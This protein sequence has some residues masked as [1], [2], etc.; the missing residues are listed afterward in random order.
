MFLINRCSRLQFLFILIGGILLGSCSGRQTLR[1]VFQKQTAHERYEQSLRSA[2][3]DN[4][5]LGRDWIEAS[6]KALR[7]SIAVSKLPFQETGYFRADRAMATGYRFKAPRGQVV[8]ITVETKA[9]QNVNIFLDLFEIQVDPTREPRRV[10]S[11][12]SASSRLEYRIDNDRPHLLRLQPELLRSGQYT[13]TILSRPSLAFPVQGKDSKAIQSVFGVPRDGGARRH[14]GVDIFAARGT[15][16]VASA[17]G[18]VTRVSETPRGGKVVWL[19]DMRNRQN[20]YYAHLDAQLVQVGQ[21]V[22]VGDTLG[23]VGNTGN[24]ITTTP[25]LHFGIYKYGEGAI[26][27]YMHVHQPPLTPPQIKANLDHLGNWGRI[28]SKNVNLRISPDP[29]AAV[30]ASL[31]QHTPLQV[32]GGTDTWFR[33]RTPDGVEGYVSASLLEPLNKPI[34]FEQL[35]AQA[36]LLEEADLS[37]APLD[38]SSLSSKVPVL[39]A[40]K[41]FLLVQNEAGDL[42]WLWQN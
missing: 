5:G 26:D 18:R 9:K 15:P 20:L 17:E 25:H 10:A 42:G 36:I 7:D 11:A 21:H 16:V 3:L 30:L 35:R 31:P 2:N 39:A 38:S 27:P 6:H 41:S 12:D 40:Y 28:T 4:T 33:V 37:A 34:R 14:E 19:S 22:K 1:G 13:L 32:F 8:D 24:A 23:L 29:K